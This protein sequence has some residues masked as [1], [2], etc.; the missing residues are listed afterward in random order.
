MRARGR[1]ALALQ[2]RRGR[3]TRA[4]GV[5]VCRRAQVEPIRNKR[6]VRTV[7]GAKGNASEGHTR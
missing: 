7:R 2:S 4:P 6:F 1:R 5:A 3:A